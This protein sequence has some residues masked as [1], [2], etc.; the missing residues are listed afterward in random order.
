M[1]TTD[2]VVL[3]VGIAVASVMTAAKVS[4]ITT[5]ETQFLTDPPIIVSAFQRATNTTTRSFVQVYNTSSE[6]INLNDWTIATSSNPA[7][8]FVQ[9]DGLLEAK[10]HAL[11]SYN[12]AVVAGIGM[13]PVITM[14]RAIMNGESIKII[15]PAD[16]SY[17]A[18]EVVQLA[19]S[20]NPQD[21]WL[22]RMTTTGYSTA[23]AAFDEIG[24]TSLSQL[25]LMNDW[26]YQSPG[27]PTIVIDEV[28]SYASD[29]SPIDKSILCGD[30]IKL[31]NVSDTI[32]YLDDLVLR[33][34]SNSSSATSS[35]AFHLSGEI[36]PGGYMTVHRT[37]DGDRIA[38]TNSG[39]YVWLADKYDF[40]YESM[41]TKYEA[42]TS[43]YQ[44]WSW[45]MNSD[46]KWQWTMTPQPNL[47]NK[48]TLPEPVIEA[49]KPCATGQY[50]NPDTNRCRTIEEA[51]NALASCPEGQERNP[52]TNR[53]RTVVLAAST[54]LVPCGEGQERNPA[55]NR[56][57]SIASAVVEL[58]P[59]DEG[60]ERNPATNR[61]K[62]VVGASTITSTI[63]QPAEVE[64]SQASIV[65]NPYMLA[66]VIVVGGVSYALYEWRSEVRD[67]YKRLAAKLGKKHS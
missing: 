58:I 4:A 21:I 29:C 1:K 53:C 23:A 9:V 20:T 59:C 27:V 64:S 54:S 28:Y 37:D 67:G 12:D 46:K 31:H 57:R 61:C 38:L 36:V 19:K 35:N 18:I 42:A 49:P 13:P 50:R 7:S 2:R 14:S 51:V 17:K 43:D 44:G 15:P 3:W 25:S 45:A 60:Y 24:S 10:Q 63:A 11:A 33:T 41:M 30:Y 66:A 56:C 48:F 52:A 34:D 62:K 22:R 40:I 16:S 8:L 65:T 55:T 5:I 6:P 39:G 26:L 47:P 32:Q